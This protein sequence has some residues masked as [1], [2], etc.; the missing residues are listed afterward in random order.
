MML[1]AYRMMH[2]YVSPTAMETFGMTLIEAQACGTPVIS[3]STGA[4]PEAVCPNFGMLVKNSNFNEMF[5]KIEYLIKNRK[6]LSDFGFS[7]SN[8]VKENHNINKILDKQI[9]TYSLN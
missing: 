8:W 4:T 3:F 9:K 1:Q 2:L 6:I 7:A 5:N